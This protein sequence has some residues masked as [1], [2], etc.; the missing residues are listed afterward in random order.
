MIG[1]ALIA[2]YLFLGYLISGHWPR[3]FRKKK[4]E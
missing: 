4:D 2:F 1:P 3:F